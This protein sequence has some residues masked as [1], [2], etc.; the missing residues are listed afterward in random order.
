MTGPD[1]VMALH[2]ALGA[3]GLLLGPL[4]LACEG[5]PRYRSTAGTAYA[6]VTAGVGL[7]AIALVA[8]DPAQLWWL[9]I[10]ALGTAGLA[11]LGRRAPVRH[12]RQWV[13]AYAHGQGGS[14]I[15][16]VT[17][18]LVVSLEGTAQLAAWIMPI[19]VGLPL[20]E[21]RVR[22]IREAVDASIRKPCPAA[23]VPRAR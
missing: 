15:A 14:Y 9:S 7:T 12:G 17:A 13:R 19:A 20:I 6:W 1:A 3:V 16:L 10:L 5:P 8:E 21:R 23:S 2:V 4:A 18:A 22:H 11:T